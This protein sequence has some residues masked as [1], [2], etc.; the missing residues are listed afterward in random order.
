MESIGRL[1]GGIAHDFN[2]IFVSIVE[3][4][5]LLKMKHNDPSTS[6]GRAINIIAQSADRVARERN[7]NG[8]RDFKVC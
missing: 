5:D 7:L 6:D 4:A 3:F 8:L 1:A 2:N